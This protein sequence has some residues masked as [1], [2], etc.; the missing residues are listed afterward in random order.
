[1]IATDSFT[2]LTAPAPP[3][4][5]HLVHQTAIY[6]EHSPAPVRQIETAS[7]VVPVIIGFAE[8]F[9]I[10]L[11]RAPA[12][13]ETYQSFTAGLTLKPVHISSTGGS[14]CVQFSLTPPG[15]RRF[16][17]LPMDELTDRMVGLDNLGDASFARL[18]A[19]LGDEPDWWRR[20]DIAQ[21]FL[22]DRLLRRDHSRSRSAWV[23]E[24][25]VRSAGMVPIGRLA[26]RAGWSRKHLAA[27]FHC[28]IGLSPKAVSR[29]ARFERARSLAA[30]AGAEGWAGIAAGCGYADQA[31]LVREFRELAGMTPS[32]WRS[33]TAPPR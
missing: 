27:R 19:R 15:A 10:A 29:I 31:H 16:F 3:G 11:G 33:M 28:E 20:L 14:S 2:L 12:P 32:E 13:D 8:P 4:L 22:T 25:I 23:Y 5:G 24:E 6:R 26:E 30:V 9:A 1:M 21:A 17:G 7:L 18:R